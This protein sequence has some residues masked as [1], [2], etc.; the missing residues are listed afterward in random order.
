MLRVFEIE[1]DQLLRTIAIGDSHTALSGSAHILGG[2]CT[3]RKLGCNLEGA[4]LGRTIFVGLLIHCAA[5]LT[6]VGPMAKQFVC[7]LRLHKHPGYLRLFD[8]LLLR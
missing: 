4:L 3:G 8:P 5:I 6:M 2:E 1:N 7:A